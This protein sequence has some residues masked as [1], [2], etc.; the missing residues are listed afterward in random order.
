MSAF[1]LY[2]T[3]WSCQNLSNLFLNVFTV[4]AQTTASDRQL[5]HTGLI[6]LLKFFFLIFGHSGAQDLAPEC[7]NV[8]KNKK[9]GLDQY[10]HERFGRLVFTTISKMWE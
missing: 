7:P 8:K 5:G 1:Q 3:S 9:G 6:H 10:D 4:S 2:R